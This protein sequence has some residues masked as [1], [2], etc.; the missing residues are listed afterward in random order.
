M[1]FDPIQERPR[2]SLLLRWHRWVGFVAALIVVVMAVTG[3]LINHATKLNLQQTH[4]DS[5]IITERYGL[6]PEP[7]PISYHLPGAWIT[8]L[9]GRLFLNATLVAEQAGQGVGAILSDGMVA[10][11]AQDQIFLMTREGVLIERLPGH[12]LPGR[13]AAIGEARGGEVVVDTDN[14]LFTS[15]SDLLEWSPAEVDAIWSTLAPLP[16]DLYQEVLQAF[17]GPGISLDRILLDVHTGRLFGSWV[18]YVFDA[19]AVAL[20]FLAI[21]GVVNGLRAPGRRSRGSGGGS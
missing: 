16:A 20:L 6:A 3:V 1:A 8:W 11:A 5:P 13:I 2:C 15:G 19:A 14:G 4:V 7:P 10:A 18:P 9:D 12:A 17:R 21:S